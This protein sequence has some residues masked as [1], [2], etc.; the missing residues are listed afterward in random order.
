M[1]ADLAEDQFGPPIA[2]REYSFL[3]NP[4]AAGLNQSV[5]TL[6]VCQVRGQLGSCM[7]C[8]ALEAAEHKECLPACT[9]RGSTVQPSLTA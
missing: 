7:G 1:T 8:C 6:Q 5:V 4:Q 2:F 3:S 9:R